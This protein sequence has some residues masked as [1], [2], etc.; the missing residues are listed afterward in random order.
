MVV[1]GEPREGG[2]PRARTNSFAPDAGV[3]ADAEVADEGEADE[4]EADE[5]PGLART[6]QAAG[7]ERR[8]RRRGRRGGRRRRGGPEDGLA[9]SIADELGPVPV[10][11]AASAVADFDGISSQPSP[12]PAEYTPSAHHAE[13]P[14]TVQPTAPT[15]AE[16]E[17]HEAEKA[18]RRRSTVRE[19]V[20]FGSSSQAEPAAPS[21]HQLPSAAAPGEA[22]LRTG[23]RNHDRSRAASARG[24][25]VTAFRRRRIE[26]SK[27]FGPIKNRPANT[28][29]F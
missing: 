1:S 21:S 19:K 4:D 25:V 13:Q 10:P 11:E 24:M 6:D 22:D 7:G 3:S 12:S 15:Q 29:R 9:G 8:P 20:S 17:A 5:Q 2:I 16:A 28:G 26:N 14:V 27:N 18:A 23:A